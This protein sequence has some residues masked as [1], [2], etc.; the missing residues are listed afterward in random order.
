M[1]QATTEGQPYRD[2]DGVG[3]A[4]VATAA[5]SE[6]I[7]SRASQ[8]LADGRGVPDLDARLQQASKAA[9]ASLSPTLRTYGGRSQGVP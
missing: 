8:C 6:F 5:F 7:Q 2:D 3:P 1:R 4:A 9:H